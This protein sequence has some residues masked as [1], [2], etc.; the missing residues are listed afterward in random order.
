MLRT[1]L[2]ASDFRTC[3]EDMA[4]S[5]VSIRSMSAS[6]TSPAWPALTAI[7][8]SATVG[9]CKRE[10]RGM[11][12]PKLATTL[13]TTWLARS[14]VQHRIC[15]PIGAEVQLVVGELVVA[16]LDRKLFG[17][18]P[19]LFLEAV[20]DRLLDLIPRK[21]DELSRRVRTRVPNGGLLRWEGIR[22]ALPHHADLR[23]VE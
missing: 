5:P 10:R 18:A 9:A 13:E 21:R 7:A 23:W 15:Y 4:S 8:V 20:G 14:V 17:E 6:A 3:S 19:Y 16:R 1:P 22:S 12:T 11:S 2:S